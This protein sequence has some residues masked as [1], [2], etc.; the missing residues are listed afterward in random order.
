VGEVYAAER[1][2]F[3]TA[4]AAG[5]PRPS[6]ARKAQR[7]ARACEDVLAEARRQHWSA[8]DGD[9]SSSAAQPEAAAAVWEVWRDL[10]ASLAADLPSRRIDRRRVSG[11]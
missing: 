7:V 11:T 9:W 4:L 10:A 8:P 2:A 1:S 6:L 3:L 5:A